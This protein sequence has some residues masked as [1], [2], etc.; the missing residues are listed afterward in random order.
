MT[1]NEQLACG[2]RVYQKKIGQVTWNRIDMCSIHYNAKKMLD[3][4]KIIEKDCLCFRITSGT[5][6]IAGCVVITA[7]EAA[8]LN[9]EPSTSR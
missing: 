2:C 5:G 6:H 3:A 1:S 9:N 8:T 4:L 7:I